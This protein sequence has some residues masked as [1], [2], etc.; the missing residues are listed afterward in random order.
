MT[1]RDLIRREDVLSALHKVAEASD[2]T[3]RRALD[4]ADRCIQRIQKVDAEIVRHSHWVKC[5]GDRFAPAGAYAYC[6]LCHFYDS[7]IYNWC[8]GCGAKMDGGAENG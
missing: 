6:H 8:H 7:N 1:M 3:Q 5:A 2:P 4:R